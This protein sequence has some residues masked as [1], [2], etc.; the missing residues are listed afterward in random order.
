MKNLNI[1]SLTS[2]VNLV[3][4]T[5]WSL[6]AKIGP[7]LVGVFAIPIIIENIGT[8]RFG[9]LTLIM[10]IVG[11][12]GLFDLGFGRAQTKLIADC[13]GREDYEELPGTF[14]VSQLFIFCFGVL[15]GVILF[16]ITPVLVTQIL[17]IS[18]EFIQESIH[19]F[20][21]LA[22]T[23]PFITLSVGFQGSLRASQR[24]DLITKVRVPLGSWNFL[25]PLLILPVSHKLSVLVL[26][27]CMGRVVGCCVF[28][29][30]CCMV[31]PIKRKIKWEL[32]RVRDLV[33]F[34]AWMTVSNIIGPLMEY[35]D[36]FM[37]G[38]LLNME[39]VAFYT[40]PYEILKRL[41]LLPASLR[42]VLFPAL[43][44][45]L[46]VDRER[47][48]RLIKRCL[49]YVLIMVFPIS[50][51]CVAFAQV[52]M[53]FWINPEFAQ[54]SAPVMQ[55]LAVGILINSLASILFVSL[56]ADGR[57]DMT[58]KFHLIELPVY[59][60]LLWILLNQIGIIGVAIAWLIRVAL[61]TQLLYSFSVKLIPELSGL[62]NMFFYWALPIGVSLLLA[63][64]SMPIMLKLAY[65]LVIMS[66]FATISWIFIL[67]HQD[68]SMILKTL[69]IK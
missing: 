27:M 55:I 68:K 51:L 67:H 50:F 20:R 69:R 1:Q 46:V 28:F 16:F 4:N 18:S 15:G 40:T 60:V 34:S 63:A 35:F 21:I 12:F 11:Y 6:G 53:A 58:A 61:D 17:N 29:I 66:I 3:K 5:F 7:L 26:L 62:A 42:E 56:Q 32:V 57:P 54:K 49:A 2:S 37:I 47:G 23:I 25:G 59:L 44:S 8:A 48:V 45:N 65:T 38:A 24:F 13:L 30:Q 10:M 43:G 36:R 41:R 9:I 52:G 31:L 14:W 19:A 64:I 33:N 39:A 22:F